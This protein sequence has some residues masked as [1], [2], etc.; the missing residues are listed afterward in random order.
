[1]AVGT[2]V[3]LLSAFSFLS[4]CLTVVFTSE[5]HVTPLKARVAAAEEAAARSRR[6][7]NVQDLHSP[8]V[9]A[10]CAPH[11]C[12]QGQLLERV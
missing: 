7:N 2:C 10:C 4:L 1:M 9:E 6:G 8:C 3:V 12:V 11:D 5:K